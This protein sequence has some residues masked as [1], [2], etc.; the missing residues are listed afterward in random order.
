MR[1][2]ATL[3]AL[4]ILLM[5]GQY[6]HTDES[7]LRLIPLKHRSADEVIPIL[8]PLLGP[9]E[10][11]TGQDYRL[12][13]RATDRKLT[14]I[15]RV[16]REIDTPL[17][18]LLI[19]VRYSGS[20]NRIEQGQEVSGEVAIGNRTRITRSPR[21]DMD[22]Q[23]LTINRQGER[24]E[25]QYRGKYRT[26]SRQ[27]EGEY[28]IRAVEGRRAYIA[29]GQSIPHVQPFLLLAGNHLTVAT[30]IIYRD[31]STGFGVTARL[32]GDQAE[33]DITPRM[34]F[35]GAGD[36]RQ[37]DFLELTTQTRVEIGRWTDI[38][39][40]LAGASHVGREILGH[41]SRRDG[42]GHAL[43]IRVDRQD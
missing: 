28:V 19:S 26:A 13:V 1:R 12:F 14:D 6:A 9:G 8:Q 42:S 41:S 33:L 32:R 7:E 27:R 34:T 38:G 3:L 21:T 39:G 36:A 15:E 40:I 17:H 29:I 2:L 4:F 22:N 5:P 37:V 25:V 24:G 30:G 35:S 43:Q 23:G 10:R 11:I 16:L 20:E 18:S 31:V